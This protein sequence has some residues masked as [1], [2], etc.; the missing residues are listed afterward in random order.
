VDV[1]FMQSWKSQFVAVHDGFKVLKLQYKMAAPDHKERAHP[2]PLGHGNSAHP[3]HHNAAPYAHPHAYNPEFPTPNYLPLRT[4]MLQRPMP[5][6]PYFHHRGIF[7]PPPPNVIPP[8]P[9]FGPPFS[10]YAYPYGALGPFGYPANPYGPHD[11]FGRVG[12]SGYAPVP[13]AT[14]HDPWVGN[15]QPSQRTAPWVHSS[16]DRAGQTQFSMCIFLPDAHDGLLGLLDTMASQPGFL[17]DLLDCIYNELRVPKFKLSFHD[18]V[19]TLLRKLGLELPF[20]PKGD[21]SDMVEDDGSGFPVEVED[22][23]HKAVVEPHRKNV[24]SMPPCSGLRVHSKCNPA[25]PAHGHGGREVDVARGLDRRQ[26]ERRD[27][28]GSDQHKKEEKMCPH[29]SQKARS[30]PPTPMA[31]SGCTR[32]CAPWL[33]SK[34]HR[35]IGFSPPRHYSPINLTIAHAHQENLPLPLRGSER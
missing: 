6:V 34:P 18:N 35:H 9:P 13:Y 29:Q 19:V 31:S 2:A 33:R 20:C 24:L 27:K 26:T 10:P 21:M 15:T 8:P 1:P 4:A 25:L 22:V 14:G 28:N 5:V 32:S 3:Y 12:P 23:I 17:H 11:P 30:R 7:A 16:S